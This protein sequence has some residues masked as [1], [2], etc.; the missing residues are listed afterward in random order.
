MVKKPV[1]D[2]SFYVFVELKGTMFN[3]PIIL[4]LLINKNVALIYSVTI[5]EHKTKSCSTVIF[6]L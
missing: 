6:Y 5:L 1:R 2:S 3:I 4:I